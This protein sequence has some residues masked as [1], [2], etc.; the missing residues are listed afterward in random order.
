M[1]KFLVT[2]KDE[3]GKS[4]TTVLDAKD[5]NDAVSSVQTQG[6]FVV[7]IQPL[8]EAQKNAQSSSKKAAQRNYT[9]NKAKLQDI[10]VFARQ[11][12]TMLEAGVPLLRSLTVILDQLESRELSMVVA[13][14]RSDV[15]Q[16]MAFSKALD[17]HPK[18]FGQFW[19]SL[20]EVG[21]ASG[22]MPRV[23]KKLTEYAE[24]SVKFQSQ[25]IGALI[26]PAV[27]TVIVFL[28][29][30]AFALFI[31]P[32]FEKVFK[33]LNMSLPGITIMMMALF[34]FIQT[35]FLLIVAAITG[36][37]FA[38]KAYV[39]TSVGRWQTEMFLY[40]LPT[41]GNI[42][43]LV[44]VEKFTSQM[45]ILI[46]SGVPI[47]YALEI[48]E[49]LV[50]NMV[51]GAVLKDVRNAVRE[52]KLLADALEK[53]SF[54]PSIS[55]QMIRVGEETGELSKMLGHVAVFYKGQVE[56]FMRNISVLIEPVMLVVMGGV[57]GTMVIAMFLPLLSISTGG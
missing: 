4:K 36:M 38:F 14:V 31:G 21:E 32:I 13:E 49:R 24:E 19:V 30:L 39:K 25:L 42:F 22:T 34:K 17:K 56:D 44:V 28:A 43:R 57:I 47:L 15:E 41:V 37:V 29:V 23:L 12:A 8:E 26:Y 50:D 45:A 51:C 40:N 54:F 2:F 52:G 48:S 6:V 3:S 33:N 55:V 35:Q 16:G 53:S 20:V 9:H 11:L 46:E 1:P 5:S 10:V 7:A 27:L 18:V